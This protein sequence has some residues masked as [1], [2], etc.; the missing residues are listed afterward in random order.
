MAARRELIGV[1]NYN[2]DLMCSIWFLLHYKLSNVML[3]NLPEV[4]AYAGA[5][6]SEA[7]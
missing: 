3:T 5:G 6:G 4:K 7:A 2:L 1:C